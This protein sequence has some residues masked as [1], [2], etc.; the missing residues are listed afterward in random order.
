MLWERINRGNDKYCE[1]VVMKVL[2]DS[3]NIY[4]VLDL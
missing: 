3:G 2:A 1:K 4:I